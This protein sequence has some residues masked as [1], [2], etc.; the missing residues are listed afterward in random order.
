MRDSPGAVAQDDVAEKRRPRFPALVQ[1]EKLVRAK[2][3]GHEKDEATGQRR[4]WKPIDIRRQLF[5]GV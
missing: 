2:T 3:V 1:L 4:S 5:I